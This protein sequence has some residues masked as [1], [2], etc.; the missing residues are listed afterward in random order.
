[1]ITVDATSNNNGD[2]ANPIEWNHTIGSGSNRLLVVTAGWRDG[3]GKWDIDSMTYDGVSMTKAKDQTG[4]DASNSEVW[5]LVNP[6]TG[7]N[8]ISMTMNGNPD[9]GASGAVSFFGVDQDNPLDA[10]GSAQASGNPSTSITTVANGAMVVDAVYSRNATLSVGANQTQMYNISDPSER[11]A[12]SYR[13]F[14][15]PGAQ[16]MTWTGSAVYTQSA[17]SFK[18]APSG[19][20]FIFNLL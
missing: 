18:P 13:R 15:A 14:G 17:A 3:G 5:Y 9:F 20:S 12:A 11:S 8:Q 7:T 16:T 10:T 1:M 4:G 19:G 2:R 6:N